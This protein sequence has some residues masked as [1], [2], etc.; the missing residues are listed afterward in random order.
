M[1]FVGSLTTIEGSMPGEGNF[2][3][4]H[5][6][7]GAAGGVVSEGQGYGIMLAGMLAAALPLDHP[8]REEVLLYGHELYLGWR[9][10]CELTTINSC[11]DTHMCGPD[12]AHECLPSWKF[13]DRMAGEAADCPWA[14][15]SLCTGSAPD[16]DEDAILGMILLVLATAQ[17]TPAP[18]WRS[19]MAL[20]AIQ[21]A[22]AFLEH[23]TVTHPTRTA[24]NGQPLRAVKLG[25]CWGG[26]DCSNP[27]YHSPGQYTAFRD[28]MASYARAHLVAA[29]NLSPQWD[30]LIETS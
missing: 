18:A 19:G 2:R 5:S 6:S 7:G 1:E 22:R 13:D 27:S 16:G 10:M 20:W 4:V 9:R 28:Y 23:Q 21:S 14:E 24:S 8:Y 17:D 25:S 26:W 11:Q 15:Q 12:G 29:P 3:V 30:A